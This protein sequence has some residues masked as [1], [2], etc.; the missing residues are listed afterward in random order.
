MPT[1]SFTRTLPQMQKLILR[2]LRV[3]DSSETPDAND[4]NTVNEAIDLRLKELHALGTLWFK[5]GGAATSLT[6]TPGSATHSLASVTDFL[7]AVSMKLRVGTEDKPV[8]I[9][10]HREYQDIRNKS[11]QGEPEKVFISGATCYFWPVPTI[12]YTAKLTYQ[13][14]TADTANPGTPDVTQAMLRSL[15]TLVASDCADDFAVPEARLQRLKS[16]AAMAEVTLRTLNA[17]RTDNT[18]VKVDYF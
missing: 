3:L 18:P 12:A 15:V 2:K 16:E 5:V 1:Y 17:E 11:E 4:A 7:F 6:L 10:S 14:I 8:E 13:A 9:I